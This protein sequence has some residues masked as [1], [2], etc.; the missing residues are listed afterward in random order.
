MLVVKRI[1][2]IGAR[3]EELSAS[4]RTRQAART[5][6]AAAFVTNSAGNSK[7]GDQMGCGS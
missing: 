3:I 2:G 1:G 6:K 5:F 4:A 7:L